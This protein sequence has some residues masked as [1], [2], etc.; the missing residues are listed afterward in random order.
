LKANFKQRILIEGEGSA[1]F[2]SSFMVAGFVD[3]ANNIFNI[4]RS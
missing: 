2:T 1:Q 3:M 4:K